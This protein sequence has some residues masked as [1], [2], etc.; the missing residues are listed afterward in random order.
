MLTVLVFVVLMTVGYIAA[1][2]A[3]ERRPPLRSVPAT[4]LRVAAGLALIRLAIQAVAAV[5]RLFHDALS[6]MPAAGT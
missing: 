1:A 4:A 5:G 3:R 6:L 2:V